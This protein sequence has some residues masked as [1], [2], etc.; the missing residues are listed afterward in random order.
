MTSDDPFRDAVNAAI[1][2]AHRLGE[3]RVLELPYDLDDRLRQ[4]ADA[5]DWDPGPPCRYR[6][7]RIAQTNAAGAR[8]LVWDR[9]R[10]TEMAQLVTWRSDAV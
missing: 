7:L 6:G 1:L 4:A 10:E 3:P 8:V 9:A 5:G 2:L